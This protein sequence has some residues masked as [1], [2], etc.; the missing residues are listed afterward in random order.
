M[1]FDRDLVERLKK[2]DGEAYKQLILSFKNQLIN[3]IYGY[4]GDRETAEDIFQETFV[5]VVRA[6]HTFKPQYSIKTWVFTIAKNLCLDHL[7]SLKKKKVVS[8]SALRGQADTVNE[9]FKNASDEC[10]EPH[11]V[12]EDAEH[13]ELLTSALAELPPI[14]K[15]ILIY[16]FFAGLGYDEIS[17]I[18]G[19]PVGTCKFRVHEGVKKLIGMLR[20][21]Q[22]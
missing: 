1:Q 21:H 11:A 20:K 2:R 8:F 12:A 3:F 14:Y 17:G 7:K 22:A 9:L 13:K 10:R 6:I 16:R 19:I 18:L 4:I 15:E 5:R